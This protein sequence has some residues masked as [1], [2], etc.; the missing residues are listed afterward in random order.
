MKCVGT[1][2]V[3][4]QT[5]IIEVFR[6]LDGFRPVFS[7]MAADGTVDDPAEFGRLERGDRYVR[8]VVDPS[9]TDV[10]DANTQEGGS[11]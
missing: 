2:K 3:I 1:I 4:E 11:E 6:T 10:L 5:T 9:L 7:Y 8:L